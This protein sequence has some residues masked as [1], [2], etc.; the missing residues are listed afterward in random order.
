[1]LSGLTVFLPAHNEEGNIEGVVNGFVRELPGVA[2]RYEIIII[3][4]GSTD[5]TGEIADRL[6]SSL[7]RV[8]VVH[9]TT[10]LGYG[11]AVNSGIR[12]AAEPY[13]LLCDGDGQFDPSDANLLASR[14][15]DHD[16]VVGR[17]RHRADN[18]VRRLNGKSWTLLMRLLFRIRI[19]DIDCGFKLFRRDILDAMELRATGAMVT[20]EL[21]A[22]LA[23]RG[24]RICEVDVRHL[25]R[26]TGEQSG[27]SAKVVFRA[28]RELFLL[29]ADLKHTTRLQR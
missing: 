9:H 12:S 1:M 4:D 7:P 29:H 8:R 24:A 3:N 19:S 20:A 18:I 16:V 21:M 10:N 5:R 14:I 26:P 17:R 23:S 13:V 22:R 28:F 6:A 27:S 2:D 11:A 25:P 15:Q